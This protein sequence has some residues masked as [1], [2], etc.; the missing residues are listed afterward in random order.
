MDNSNFR[1]AWAYGQPASRYPDDDCSVFDY[2]YWRDASCTKFLAPV[3]CQRKE[4]MAAETMYDCADS[5]YS[6]GN[7][8]QWKEWGL[9]QSQPDMMKQQCKKTCDFCDGTKSF[10]VSYEE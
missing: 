6:V 2:G 4:P 3:V 10:S 5:P 9:C 8:P 1:Q 7:C